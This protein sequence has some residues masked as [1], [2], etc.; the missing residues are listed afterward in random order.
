MSDV[1]IHPLN[2]E[3]D[4]AIGKQGDSY[5]MYQVFENGELWIS[6][7]KWK[8]KKDKKGQP[9]IHPNRISKLGTKEYATLIAENIN[10]LLNSEPFTSLYAKRTKKK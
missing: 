9:I 4:V 2:W 5:V 7:P 1:T 6:G 8:Q 10:K 3:G